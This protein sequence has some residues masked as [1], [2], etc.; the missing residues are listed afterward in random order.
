MI[1]KP[2]SGLEDFSRVLLIEDD[3]SYARL[4]ELMLNES[5]LFRCEVVNCTT[6]EA[7]MATLETDDNF[8]AVL[9]D[10]SLPDSTGFSTLESLLTRFPNQNI[11]VLTGLD[12]EAIGVSAVKAGAQDF[13]IKRTGILD[14]HLLVKTLRFSK[15]RKQIISRLEEAQ[16]AARLGHWECRPDRHFFFASDEVYRIFDLDPSLT[17]YSC[18]DLLLPECPLNP[19][20]I[21][22]WK[23][24][25][26]QER[27]EELR[28]RL[29]SDEILTVLLTCKAHQD[30]DGGVYYRG[31]VQDITQQKQAEELR[32]ARDLAEHTAKVREKVIASVSHEMRT[33][34]NAIMGFSSLLLQTP[35]QP[36]QTRY[37]TS[38][39]QSSELLLDIINDILQVSALQH[40]Q[41]SLKSDVFELRPLLQQ[42]H[43]VMHF[44]AME[45]SLSLEI[46]CHDDVPDKL[47]GDPQ[48]L[49]QVL[50]NL[51]GNALKFTDK[52]GVKV[53]VTLEAH[54]E[55]Q[56]VLHFAVKD[57]GIGI[58]KEEL[59]A[60]FEAFTR[61][62]DK[63]RFY[64][65]IGLGLSIARML[66]EE[67]GG[68][69][70]AESEVGAGSV[71]HVHWPL[72]MAAATPAEQ[73]PLVDDSLYAIEPARILLVEDHQLN[74]LVVKH[75]LEKK[76]P[77]LTV[78][79][80]NHGDEAIQMMDQRDYAL[81]LMD[82]QMPV[83]D[84]Y[85]TT[86]YI[87]QHL[88]APKSRVPILAMTAHIQST[89]QENC[90]NVGINDFIMKPFEQDQLFRIIHHYLSSPYL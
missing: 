89:V 22:Q 25:P 3:T 84:G 11:I 56:V 36:E 29:S 18:D 58:P 85:E 50:F 34:M 66:V 42:L 75:L 60:I 49:S 82:L 23:I 55:R 17:T 1:Y 30:V 52:G 70:W 10:L 73:S 71:F 31:I 72:L 24:T 35:L 51:V 33:P 80:A 40:G 19:L 54:S 53:T 57:S 43:S 9:L 46:S 26:P 21:L 81:I 14:G 20:L 41:L 12:D 7:G 64:E 62:T 78:E 47:V 37:V 15:E 16:R 59:E 44:R 61:I 28:V 2:H 76:W 88:T 83:R 67:Y 38:I 90:R 32:K 87:R 8:A 86:T 4:V 13:L 69:L 74:Q 39:L 65:G 68:R 6:L 48:R 5:E 79:V 45:K 63:D 27:S 77:Q